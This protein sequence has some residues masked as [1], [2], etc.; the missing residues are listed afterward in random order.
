MGLGV[1]LLLI[2]LGLIL[3]LAVNAHVS[4]IAVHTI[5]WILVVIGGVV[6]E[7]ETIR[8]FDNQ[9]LFGKRVLITR[10]LVQ[11]DDFALQLWE[12]GAEPIVAPT[13]AIGRVS[14][15]AR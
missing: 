8:W 3:A 15:R 14:P 13:I 2:A 10:P 4:G 12:A 9:P 5:G 1:S 7:R 6:N 11:A